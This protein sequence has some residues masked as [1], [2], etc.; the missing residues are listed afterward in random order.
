MVKLHD[1]ILP[2]AFALLLAGGPSAR[3]Y[4]R[5]K[6]PTSGAGNC[7]TCHGDFTDG[8]S[9]VG[10][11]FPSG[12]KHEMHRGS[13]GMDAACD[14]CHTAADDRNP[15]IGSSDGTID[16]PGLGCV[17]C[18]GRAEDAGN[19]LVSNGLG[20][21]LRQHHHL[22]GVTSC[23][24]CHTD[25]DPMDAVLVGEHV[26]PPYYGSPDTLVAM[27]CNP[28]A[29]A[30]VNEN[31]SVGDFVGIDNDGDGV[32]DSNDPDCQAGTTT[33]STLASSTTTSTSAT[34]SSSTIV[35][36]TTST[37]T[38]I[39]VVTT[40][41]T[42]SVTT[43]SIGSSTTTSN[44]ATTSSSSTAT[45]APSS[46]TSTTGTTVPTSSTTTSTSTVTSTS[47]TTT[48]P[49]GTTVFPQG[50]KLLVKQKKSGA[51]RLKLLA[52]DPAV[53]ASPPCDAAGELVVQATGAG[54]LAR[55]WD[56]DPIY[57]KPI[58]AKTPE[59]GCKYR[60]G[61]VVVTVLVKAGNLLKLT[62]QADDLGIPLDAD[63]RPVQIELRHGD[64]RHCLDFGGDGKHVIGKKLLSK[65][66]DPAASCPGAD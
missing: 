7:S 9:P 10:T 60:K 54:A 40:V 11:V 59:K 50:T 36:T 1:G 37:S 29:L 13:G 38:S 22:A 62:A 28:S 16:T 15:F 61:P 55:R 5:Y 14:L 2:L 12:D 44:S 42:S 34:S 41:T 3:A 65:L 39:I 56:L 63:P 46:T 19:D 8:T 48:T 23:A 25:A 35:V 53:Q 31:W 57:W 49:P 30:N 6:N 24:N 52:K 21:G 58:K 47:T 66:A 4:E 27:S 51:Q 33:T 32:F 20:A 43:T 45:T 64:V 17:G 18:H 26:P